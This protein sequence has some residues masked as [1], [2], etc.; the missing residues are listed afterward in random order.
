M[1]PTPNLVTNTTSCRITTSTPG[2]Y[3]TN[4]VTVQGFI[5]D[6]TGQ[7]VFDYEITIIL[8]PDDFILGFVWSDEFGLDEVKAHAILRDKVATPI[9]TRWRESLDTITAYTQD[10]ELHI[11]RGEQP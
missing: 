5:S 10:N 11:L 2:N 4:T 3:S 7:S 1:E 9:H 6:E 8:L